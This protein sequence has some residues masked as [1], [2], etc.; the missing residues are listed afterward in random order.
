MIYGTPAYKIDDDVT[1]KIGIRT[2]T[3][4]AMWQA[5]AGTIAGS[6]QMDSQVP[7]PPGVSAGVILIGQQ[8]RQNGGSQRTS[9]TFEGINGDGKSVTFK[10]RANTLDYGFQP[11]FAQVDIKL[12]PNFQDLLTK[13]GG[14]VD[15]GDVIWPATISSGSQTTAGLGGSAGKDMTNPMF[16]I[17]DFL[18]LEGTYTIRYAALDPT[19]SQSGVGKIFTSGLPGV[20]P[21]FG[22]DRNWLKAPKP[23]PAARTGV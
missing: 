6:P 11:G 16:G 20:A 12:A 23:L 17:Q 19:Q 14:T 7:V 5:T 22:D 10:T 4:S 13:Y 2:V 1:D 18:R 15:G 8:T 9:W 21:T 3:I